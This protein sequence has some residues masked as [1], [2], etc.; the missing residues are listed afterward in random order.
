MS[1]VPGTHPAVVEHAKMGARL[2]PTEPIRGAILVLQ[3]SP[4]QETALTSLLSAQ[5]D[6]TSGQFHKWLTPE[7]FGESF[8]VAQP[9]IAQ[10]SA[11]LGDSGFSV[12]SVSRSGRF[13]VFS[14]TAGAVETAF[15]TEMHRL[16]VNGEEH[17]SNTT[18]ISIPSALAS[19]VKGVAQ[20]NDFRP[21]SN[22]RK[23]KRV[24]LYKNAPN[25][26]ELA[27]PAWT[28][29]GGYLFHA[30]A[31]GDIATIY[32]ATPL[33]ASGVDGTG[34]TIAVIGDSNVNLSDAQ[35]FRSLFGLPKNDPHVIVVGS[36]PGV[37]NF[38]NLTA[39]ANLD[40]EMAGSLATGATV[41]LITASGTQQLQGIAIAGLYAVD[42]N[43]GDIITM[44]FGGCEAGFGSSYA[45]FWNTLW[46]QAAAQGQ[47]VF[48]STGDTGAGAQYGPGCAVNGADFAEGG[49]GVNAVGSSAYNVA[50]GGT[51]FFDPGPQQYW[52]SSRSVKP[53]NSA[54]GY[55][56]EAAW[57]EGTLSTTLLNEDS[58]ALVA[59]DGT[60]SGGGGV[61]IYT[62][63]PAWQRGPGV[64]AD[65]DPAGIAAG[66]PI[67][68][69]HR[70]V[71]DI[72][73]L[74]GDHDGTLFCT[75]GDCGGN[76]TYLI[77]GDEA[78]GTS[79]AAPTMASAQALI[80]SVNG[81]RQ[82]NVNF[83]YYALARQDSGNSVTACQST[84]GTIANPF[85]TLPASTCNFHDIVA[86][87]N[88]VPGFDGDTVGFGFNAGVG[89]DETTGLGSVNIAN[90]AK[91]WSSV[92]FTSS[93]TTFTLTPATGIYGS[94]QTVTAQ[95]SSDSGT[96]AGT[97]SLRAN[98]AKLPLT[99]FVLNGGLASGTVTTLPGG[100]YSVYAHYDGDGTYSAS[101]SAPVTVTI[102]KADSTT[103]ATVYDLGYS[104]PVPTNTIPY[105]YSDRPY[106][107][108]TV[109]GAASGL[110]PGGSVTFSVQ[111]NGV[112]LAPLTTTLDSNGK[113]Y[114]FA[115]STAITSLNPPLNYPALFPGSYTV[116]ANYTGTSF[117]DSSASVSFVVSKVVPA[118]SLTAATE[119]ILTDRKALLNLSIAGNAYNLP[120]PTGT[121]TYTDSA[122]N[123]V[124]GTVSLTN[125]VAEFRTPA[126]TSAG[127]HLITASYSG[128]SNYTA[129]TTTVTVL[130]GD[131]AK[132]TTTLV[133]GNPGAAVGGY[134]YLVATVSPVPAA[135]STVSF[136]EGGVLV[137]TGTTD[138]TSGM[139]YGPVNVNAA[140]GHNYVAVFAGDQQYRTSRASL[141]VTLAK[142]PTSLL[143]IAGPN[144]STYGTSVSYKVLLTNQTQPNGWPATLTGSVQL[145]AGGV[146]GK[147]LGSGV[148]I[149]NP[150]LQA[151]GQATITTDLNRTHSR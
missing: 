19:V 102:G 126:L 98:S 61:S 83:Y 105:S 100:T 146:G 119:D 91:N 74:A 81:G 22:L 82:G 143:I 20:L 18:D 150:N 16:T 33:T 94:V 11:W 53:F 8:G 23:G 87:S 75:E 121:V 107:V 12:D 131:A 41:D 14:G 39:E 43:I 118:L 124:L 51:M 4:E 15:H 37:N 68:G 136:Y 48:V 65:S 25:S 34:T 106:I 35:T 1:R 3:P 125:S 103:A 77:Y 123:A 50:V 69:L 117:A 144:F 138:P 29:G 99:A 120:P 63:R 139:A 132:S 47:T 49:Y 141:K 145:Y 7:S 73:M 97:V 26:V 112:P 58:S 122:T 57:N 95:V 148:P 127:T 108:A 140:G 129:T 114:L 60:G 55:I 90:V 2:A 40:I 21:K 31:P 54:L 56:P 79:V 142:D 93:T 128:D 44:S 5:Q 46:A 130:V 89:F 45:D 76:G 71:P 80:N 67:T 27:Q 116:F 17:I 36:D 110:V 149:L 111:K 70:L 30:V 24:S 52:Q 64:P 72:A 96:P 78:G 101:D 133:E 109:S 135:Y 42:N 104:N 115:G 147:L 62:G 86:G 38:D 28:P 92:Q 66:S 10:V 137:G 59:G 13:V 6:K 151:N 85:V 88:I 9:D 113:A 84:L 32:N 134:D